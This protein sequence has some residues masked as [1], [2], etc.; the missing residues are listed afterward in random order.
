M[1]YPVTQNVIERAVAT[2]GAISVDLD[3][4]YLSLAA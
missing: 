3:K 4:N 1:H 2:I